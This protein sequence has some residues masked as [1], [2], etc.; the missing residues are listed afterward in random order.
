MTRNRASQQQQILNNL[1]SS[2]VNASGNV[3]DQVTGVPAA[4]VNPQFALLECAF[5]EFDTARAGVQTQL[6][7]KHLACSLFTSAERNWARQSAPPPAL[8]TPQRH[9]RQGSISAGADR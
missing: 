2:S 1:N 8:R 4:L 5:S 7:R 9:Q 3:V 6:D